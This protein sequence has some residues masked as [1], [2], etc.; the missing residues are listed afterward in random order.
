MKTQLRKKYLN[1]RINMP[2]QEVTS[3]SLSIY[4]KLIDY[5]GYTTCREIFIYVSNDNEVDTRNII[6]KALKDNKKVA[7][8]KVISKRVMKFYYINTMND[9]VIGKFNI[10]EPVTTIEAKPT[11]Q[12]LFIMPGIVFD[13]DKNRIGFGGGY[14]DYYLSQCQTKFEKIALCYDSQIVDRII[15][16]E[17]DINPDLILTESKMFK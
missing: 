13:Y 12:T 17:H 2:K 11:V 15:V 16:D 3:K 1:I 4:N 7:V 6:I 14:Y 5:N 9:L 8:P 10:L